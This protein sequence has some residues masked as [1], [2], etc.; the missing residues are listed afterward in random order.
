MPK[1]IGGGNGT[2]FLCKFNQKIYKFFDR[3]INL[4]ILFITYFNLYSAGLS[5]L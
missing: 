5:N 4:V 2:Q 3:L 1:E